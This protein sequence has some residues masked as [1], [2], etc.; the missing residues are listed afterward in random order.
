MNLTGQDG[1]TVRRLLQVAAWRRW[2]QEH[3][4]GTDFAT[5]ADSIDD[6][7]RLGEIDLLLCG[8]RE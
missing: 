8:L 4:N 6:F 2:R 5:L 1:R 3:P 7:T